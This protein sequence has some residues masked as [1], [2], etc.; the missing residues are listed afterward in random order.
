VVERITLCMALMERH[1]A[2][3]KAALFDEGAAARRP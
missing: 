3:M 1:E 2:A